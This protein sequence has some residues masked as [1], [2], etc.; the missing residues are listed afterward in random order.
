MEN[1]GLL[2]S[3]FFL[4]FIYQQ[5][6]VEK[7]LQAYAA[8]RVDIPA[9]AG[10]G[11]KAVDRHGQ[12][13]W[14]CPHLTHRFSTLPHTADLAQPSGID[15]P[16][17]PGYPPSLQVEHPV[18]QRRI[19]RT[20]APESRR[21]GTRLRGERRPVGTIRLCARN[22]VDCFLPYGCGDPCR[23]DVIQGSHRG[24]FSNLDHQTVQCHRK[25]RPS[26][27]TMKES[28]ARCRP[29]VYKSTATDRRFTTT[30]QAF[31]H[32]AWHHIQCR[33]APLVRPDSARHQCRSGNRH[34]RAHT[35]RP[36]RIGPA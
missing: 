15:I 31:L 22:A 2:P 12:P 36:C 21:T 19:A 3:T 20:V 8:L 16:P 28:Y 24:D 4:S 18:D 6:T 10:T 26:L 29:H 11:G 25:P 23:P 9:G 1:G 5:P 13:R 30:W 33:H 14:G 32:L 7:Y 34:D 35:I 27:Q 17:N